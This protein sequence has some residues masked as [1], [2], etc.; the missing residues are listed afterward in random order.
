MDAPALHPCPFCAH[1]QPTL[2]AVERDR[3]KRI[4][5]GMAQGDVE[6]RLSGSRL[7]ASGAAHYLLVRWHTH[8]PL[9]SR[10]NDEATNPTSSLLKL[11][12]DP[13]HETVGRR[14][15]C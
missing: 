1:E 8:C 7:T 11:S 15:E 4:A 14:V 10:N 13:V 5:F 3:V 12:A 6:N 9:G 2:A